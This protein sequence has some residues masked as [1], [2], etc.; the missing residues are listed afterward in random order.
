MVVYATPYAWT[1]ATDSNWQDT[2]NYPWGLDNWDTTGYPGLS[3]STDTATIDDSNNNPATLSGTLPQGTVAS[4]TLDA[5]TAGAAVSFLHSGGTNGITGTTTLTAGSTASEDATAQFTGGTL[6]HGGNVTLTAHDDVD[7]DAIYWINGGTVAFNSA[8]LILNGGD[9]S[10][11][12]G[13][14]GE[15]LLDYDSGTIS[16]NIDALTMQGYSKVDT[17]QSMTIGGAV[18]VSTASD[19]YATINVSSGTFTASSVAISGSSGYG[20]LEKTGAGTFTVTNSITATAGST[21]GYH[22]KFLHSDGTTSVVDVYLRGSSSTNARAKLDI[23]EDN[24]SVSGN[25]TVKNYSDIELMTGKST[26]FSG[27]LQIGDDSENYD[28]H[29]YVNDSGTITV[30]TFVMEG[31]TGGSGSTLTVV[32][33]TT[34]QTS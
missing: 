19:T 17:A 30:A 20:Q 21:S 12:S 8:N 25:V 23:D 5:E 16:N 7:S 15:A 29:L 10:Q 6:T 31:N 9:V 34:L 2:T 27:T 13:N 32:D 1:G 22:A 26:T 33:S 11:G 24:F 28:G 14:Y 4:L 18:T 3:L